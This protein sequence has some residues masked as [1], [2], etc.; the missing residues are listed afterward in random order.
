[1]PGSLILK[2][3]PS[4]V[5][6]RGGQ[7]AGF[8]RKLV[9]WADTPALRRRTQTH[10]YRKVGVLPVLQTHYNVVVFSGDQVGRF[11]HS[12]YGE[13]IEPNHMPQIGQALLPPHARG[14]A[15]LG[16]EQV[17][18]KEV[19]HHLPFPRH[20]H[21]TPYHDSRHAGPPAGC[22]LRDFLA[23][24]RRLSPGRGNREHHKHQPYKY[25]RI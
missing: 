3:Q 5:R 19:G 22:R 6:P 20:I 10:R 13:R 17:S 14:L 16:G 11:E 24:R 8:H 7:P 25:T 2:S 15:P 12:L 9:L 23:G 4:R 18:P 1:M 21:T